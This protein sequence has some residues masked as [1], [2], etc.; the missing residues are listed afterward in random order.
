MVSSNPIELV[1]QSGRRLRIP[2]V[3]TAVEI[4]L[5]LEQLA[6]PYHTM[7]LVAACLGL[8]VSEIIGLQ[9]G[10]WDWDNMTVMIQRAVVQCQV[11][12]TETEGSARP[13]P[14]NPDL[15][16]CLRELQ[17]RSAYHRPGDW[18]FAND[19]GHPR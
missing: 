11:G 15:A 1:R 10:D 8:R 18:V 14:L 19:A 13:L 17:K 9:W 5:L 3:L 2:R 16:V 7:V 12:E 6:V 4:R